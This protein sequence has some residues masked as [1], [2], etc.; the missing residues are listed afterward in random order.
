MGVIDLQDPHIL[1]DLCD[2]SE[3]NLFDLYDRYT[4]MGYVR[5]A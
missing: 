4:G 2:L 3:W 5:S 1:L